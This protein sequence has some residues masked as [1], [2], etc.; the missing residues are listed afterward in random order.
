MDTPEKEG[1]P[2]PKNVLKMQ[3]IGLG[4]KE[5]KPIMDIM[6]VWYLFFASMSNLTRMQKLL[7]CVSCLYF[8]NHT[9]RHIC[10][11]N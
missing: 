11:S 8:R 2:I 9:T 7:V 4:L 5:L 1:G 6:T 10:S 3:A